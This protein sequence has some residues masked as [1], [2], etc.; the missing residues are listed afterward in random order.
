MERGEGQ[1]RSETQGM[2]KPLDKRE[3]S[4]P[5]WVRCALAVDRFV[6]VLGAMPGA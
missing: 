6:Y 4:Q 3:R 5:G 1:K 2:Y